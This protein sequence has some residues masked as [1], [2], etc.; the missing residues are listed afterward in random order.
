[1]KSAFAKALDPTSKEPS[2]GSVLVADQIEAEMFIAANETTSNAY[3]SS[4]RSH[5][6]NLR[7]S[8]DLLFSALLTGKG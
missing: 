1:M 5:L 6:F 4:V 8:I 3:R 7:A 2:D